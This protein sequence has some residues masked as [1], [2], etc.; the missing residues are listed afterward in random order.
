VWGYVDRVRGGWP[1]ARQPLLENSVFGRVAGAAGSTPPSHPIPIGN[2]PPN[3][4]RRPSSARA[5]A[6]ASRTSGQSCSRTHSRHGRSGAAGGA[7]YRCP[8]A[9]RGRGRVAPPPE[10][11]VL[12]IDIESL[13]ARAGGD[14][15]DATR[16][17]FALLYAELHRLAESTLRRNGGALSL[18][19]TTLVHEAYLNLVGRPDVAFAERGRFLAYASHAMRGLVIDHARRRGA[20]KR[21]R[22]LEITLDDEAPSGEAARVA[23]ELAQLG[24]ALDEL[25]ALEPVLA[26]VVEMHFF[27]GFTFA[28]IASLRGLSERTV[29]REWRK[30]RMVLHH[31]LLA[32]PEVAAPPS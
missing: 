12:S 28:E 32:E 25:S 6:A 10:D 18:G 29:Q 14:D 8:A 2:G 22:H 21:G 24:D 5:R 7:G 13:I 26:E 3:P 19:T 30:A 4:T 31:A 27:G 17:L 9:A 11:R 16:E 1:P 20:A 15:P 23:E